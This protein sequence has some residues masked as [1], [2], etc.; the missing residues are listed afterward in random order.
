VNVSETLEKASEGL[1]KLK[2]QKNKSHRLLVKP[3]TDETKQKI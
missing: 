2:N 1:G 3:I